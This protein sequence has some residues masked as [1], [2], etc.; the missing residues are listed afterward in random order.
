M[1][2]LRQDH[3]FEVGLNHTVSSGLSWIQSKTLSQ[4]DEIKN[5]SNIIFNFSPN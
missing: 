4:K 2:F 3:D 5:H 1:R